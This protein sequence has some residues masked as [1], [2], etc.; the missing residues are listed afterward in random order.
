M[1]KNIFNASGI[2]ENIMA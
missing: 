2:D 1:K